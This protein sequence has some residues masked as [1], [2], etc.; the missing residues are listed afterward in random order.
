[1]VSIVGSREKGWFQFENTNIRLYTIHQAVFI[2][3]SLWVELPGGRYISQDP[4]TE[5]RGVDGTH[6]DINIFLLH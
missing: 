1:M 2:L 3:L 4:D 5:T 6:Q